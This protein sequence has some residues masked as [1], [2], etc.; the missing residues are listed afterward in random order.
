MFFVTRLEAS[1]TLFKVG[2]T[3]TYTYAYIDMM[4]IYAREKWKKNSN[5]HLQI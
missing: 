2:H 3:Y 5:I 4:N 1:L